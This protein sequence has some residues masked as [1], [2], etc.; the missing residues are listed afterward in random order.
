MSTTKQIQ[1]S[2]ANG[3]KSKGP[4]TPEGKLVS[5]RNSTRHGLF[6]ETIVLEAE[7]TARFVELVE[8]LF[9]EHNPRTPTERLLVENIAAARWRQWR[10]WG[11]QKVAFDH[12]VAS[13]ST[14]NDPPLRA[15]L[16]W[17]NSAES[18][19]THELLLRYEI[20]LDRQ[21]SRSLLRL[22]QM[23]DRSI[24]GTPHTRQHVEPGPQKSSP[25]E[26]TQQPVETIV[27]PQRELSAE[28]PIEGKH[29]PPVRISPQPATTNLGPGRT[30]PGVKEQKTQARRRNGG[31]G[32]V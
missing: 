9:E 27:P 3:A 6:A 23:Q 12:E 17:R 21:I 10:I 7:N 14:T 25:A 31:T 26:R 29:T 24:K 18:I 22:Q 1:A 15:V 16:A 28:R 32:R 4:A 5:S 20:A 30:A 2:R 19:R 11:M 13:P 8:S